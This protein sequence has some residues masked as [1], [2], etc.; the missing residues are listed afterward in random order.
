MYLKFLEI[1]GFKSFSEK[2]KMKFS[3]GITVVVG[4]NGCGKSNLVD[5][6]RWGLGGQSVKLLRGSK[7]EELIFCG[8]TERKPLN[9]AEV[10]LVFDKV[11]QFLSLDYRE[12]A[13]TR[14]IYR[15]GEGEFYINNNSCRLRDITELFWDTG[16]GTETYSFIGQGRVEQLINAKPEEHRELF[17]EAAEIYRY[18]QRK[19]TA[20]V[21][22]AELSS[23]LLRIEDLLAELTGQQASL[24]QEAEKARKYRELSEQLSETEKIILFNEYFLH[25]QQLE[26]TK[27]KMQN[28]NLAMEAKQKTLTELQQKEAAACLYEEKKL[29]E[30]EQKKKLLV[31]QKQTIEKN[32]H[33]LGLLKEQKRFLIDKKNL[34]EES[35]K[36]LQGRI[37]SLEETCAKNVAELGPIQEEQE[38][39]GN[40]ASVLREKIT[41]LKEEKDLIALEALRE[42]VMELN[43]EKNTLEHFLQNNR[44]R[45]SELSESIKTLETEEKKKG[46][47]LEQLLKKR[48]QAIASIQRMQILQKEQNYQ[49]QTS[50]KVIE[51]LSTRIKERQNKISSLQ[52]LLTK[53]KAHLQYLKE[54][55]KNLSL[56]HN[57]VQAVLRASSSGQALKDVF[58]P[59]ASLISVPQQLERAIDVALGAAVQHIVVADD[60]SAS[61]AIKFLKESRAGRATFL[62]LNLLRPSPRKDVPPLRDGFLGVAN[63]LVQVPE[64]FK[65]VVDYLL[66]G[67]LV[68]EDLERALQLARSYKGWRIVTLDGEMIT[69]GGAISGG[70]QPRERY[71]LLERKG[72]L[73]KLESEILELKKSNNSNHEELDI[74]VE[75]YQKEQQSAKNLESK[76]KELEKNLLEEVSSLERLNTEKK[77]LAEDLLTLQGKKEKLFAQCRELSE[78]RKHKEAELERICRDLLQKKEEL[79]NRALRLSREEEE[80]KELEKVLVDVRVRFSAL[81]EKES[82]I[83]QLLQGYEEEKGRLNLL[84]AGLQQERL[85]LDKELKELDLQ[86]RTLL[87]AQ[88]Q[89]SKEVEKVEK[90]LA[91][92][93]E[94]VNKFKQ[95]KR[96]LLMAKEKWQRF[97]E[98]SERNYQRL[99]VEYIKAEEGLKYLLVQLQDRYKVTPELLQEK[100]W[101]QEESET[102]LAQKKLSLAHEIASMGDVNV[103]VIEEFERLQKRISFL[104]KQRLDILEGKKGVQKIVEELDQHMEARFLQTFNAIKSNFFEIFAKLFGGGQASLRL[105][106]PENILD[107]GIE[108]VAQPPGKK[109]Q[110]INLLSGGEKALTAIALL[111]ALLQ[112][113]PVP[114]CILD[115]IDSS[116]DE[117]NLTRFLYYL[118]KHVQDTQ[119]IIIT[120][121]RQTMEE[122]DML[123]G[124]T[125]EEKGVS[126][127]ISVNLTKK[128]G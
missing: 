90:L 106:D 9:Y 84:L 6:V 5:A 44:A 74:L 110:N 46:I 105:S 40:K 60:T 66:G 120:H 25:K 126:K 80:Y 77:G 63:H 3:P 108:I 51:D 36:E 17:E 71:G 99:N 55:E 15:S 11:D 97:L 115:E 35:I 98:R 22:L 101:G 117:N 18:K 75:R 43:L 59:V 47:Q 2:V 13:I 113:K 79:N 61:A 14:R 38:A 119:F 73:K 81:Q 54:S 67:V 116:L 69:P 114:F 64:K 104:E 23:N 109:L 1:I 89:E 86:E 50:L 62:P 12:I 96:D 31:E 4:P 29:A 118:K 91:S 100:Q 24:F 107:S 56:Y 124:I 102:I 83:L 34:K 93:Q 85:Q 72:E 94:E 16:I 121:R 82:N 127:V 45:D 122:A 20:G 125:M 112:Y 76:N 58:G 33:N 26:K 65:K 19:K 37:A 39:L 78:S 88:E 32:G 111:F 41:Q 49:L 123:Y 103:G 87:L 27:K 21:Q 57:G 7:M 10:S 53:K 92:L 52:G 70:Y 30:L 128:A 48:D 95:E 42:Q 28:I 8:S 68:T